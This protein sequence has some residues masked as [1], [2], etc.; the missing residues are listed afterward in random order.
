MRV[1][2]RRVVRGIVILPCSRGGRFGGPST[3]RCSAQALLILDGVAADHR[4]RAATVG[5]DGRTGNRRLVVRGV[6]GRPGEVLVGHFAFSDDR[7]AGLAALAQEIRDSRIIVTRY[8]VTK[9]FFCSALTL[10]GLVVF[11]EREPRLGPRC[12]QHPSA[13]GWARQILC[14]G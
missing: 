8:D 6:D 13:A 7:T 9:S 2:F 3:F 1:V 11:S 12:E 5:L 10:L 4:G 14:R